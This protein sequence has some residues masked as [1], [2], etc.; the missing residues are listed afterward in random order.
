MKICNHHL[1]NKLYKLHLI[2]KLIVKSNDHVQ[3][4]MLY[5]H[6]KLILCFVIEAS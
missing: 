1:C 2:A 6:Q 4:I 5:D 3:V